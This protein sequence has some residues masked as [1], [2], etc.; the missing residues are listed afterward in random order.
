MR[1]YLIDTKSGTH[2]EVDHPDDLRAFY[3]TLDCETIDI[4]TRTLG[5]VKYDIVC[6]DEALLTE[7]PI[8]SAINAKRDE[9]MLYGSILFFHNDGEGNLAPITEDDVRNIRRHVHRFQLVDDAE[10]GTASIVVGLE[11]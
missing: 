7:N 10:N 9:V 4:V 3:E 1:S 8:P 5:G 6:D 11:Y 2:R